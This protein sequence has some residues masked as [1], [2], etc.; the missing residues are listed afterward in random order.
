MMHQFCH[1][2]WLM[3]TPVKNNYSY[4]REIQLKRIPNIVLRLGLSPMPDM[5]KPLTEPTEEKVETIRGLR[6]ENGN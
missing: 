4:R 1:Y 3:A 5:I 2:Y 6:C